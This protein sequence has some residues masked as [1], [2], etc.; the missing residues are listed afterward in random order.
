MAS[1]T[2][3]NLD[4]EVKPRLRV[5][6]AEH[7]PSM[8]EEARIMRPLSQADGRI[9]AI[10]HSRGAAVATRKVRDFEETGIEVIDPW[11]GA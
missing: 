1:I 3:R 5:R 4:D 2:I 11:P 7:R 9:A 8:E 10:A 6:A